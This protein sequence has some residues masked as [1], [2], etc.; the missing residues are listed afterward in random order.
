MARQLGAERAREG[1]R[2]HHSFE[3]EVEDPGFLAHHLARGGEEQRRR[4]PQRRAHELLQRLCHDVLRRD[5]AAAVAI[6]TTI[7]PWQITT[8]AEG[9][10]ALISIDRPPERR[11]PKS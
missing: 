6:A 2:Q 10:E 1:G 8:I 11:Q 4:Q 3:A 9:T 5:S 7:T